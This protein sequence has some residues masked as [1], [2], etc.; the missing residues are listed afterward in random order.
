MYLDIHAHNGVVVHI[1]KIFGLVLL[2]RRGVAEE[3]IQGGGDG[4]LEVLR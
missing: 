4:F 2:A 3:H 1:H